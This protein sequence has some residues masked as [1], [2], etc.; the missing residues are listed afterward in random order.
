M[1]RRTDHLNLRN[2]CPDS[3]YCTPS[4]TFLQV[5]S[6]SIRKLNFH[7]NCKYWS[8]FCILSCPAGLMQFLN[9]RFLW[10]LGI[11]FNIP[12]GSPLVSYSK[13]FTNLLNLDLYSI[14]KQ[15]QMSME[16]SLL[17]SGVENTIHVGGNLKGVTCLWCTVC[18]CILG[19]PIGGT[20]SQPSV[21]VNH[22]QLLFFLWCEENTCLCAHW[23]YET[24]SIISLWPM[25]ICWGIG[26]T[27]CRCPWW[28]V[29]VFIICLLWVFIP[30]VQLGFLQQNSVNVIS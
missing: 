13:W 20:S 12:T 16:M 23:N 3:I 30:F 27:N 15:I 22:P 29:L 1:D 8:T 19:R 6:Y 24:D 4:V 9:N 28:H 14:Y 18:I 21:L 2:T 10:G 26:Q 5:Q 25:R 7:S 17:K 11:H